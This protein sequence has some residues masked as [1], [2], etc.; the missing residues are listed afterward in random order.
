MIGPRRAGKS[1]FALQLLADY[2]FAYINFDDE[3]LLD[4]DNYDLFI[5]WIREVYGD[6]RYILFDE[7]QN[8]NRWE[9]FVNRLQR[10]GF[11]IIITGS[12]ARLLS[13]ELSTHL[14]GRFIE[15]NIFPFSFRE[16][17]RAK[18]F[19]YD[20]N[21]ISVEMEGN[22]LRALNEYL[23]VGAYPEVI[24]KGLDQKTYLTT[25]FDSVLFKDVVNRYNVRYPSK[26]R[27]LAVNLVAGFAREYSYSRLNE[28]LGFRSVHTVQEYSNYIREVFIYF[29]LKRY[30]FSMRKVIKSP[31]KAY[32]YDTGMATVLKTNIT[33]DYGHL[34]ENAV[35]VEL[36]RRKNEI[37]YWRDKSGW[38]IDFVVKSRTGIES[39]IQV[40]YDFTNKDVKKR[41]I[42]SILKA[43]KELR[44]SRKYI[45]TWDHVEEM[46]ISGEKLYCLPLYRWLL[47]EDH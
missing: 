12:N 19:H 30:A 36:I 27:D 41:E 20:I 11:N 18:K 42:K 46:D 25:L 29:S 38:E 23:Q 44:P 14:T 35:A 47:K 4:I 3:R 22:L 6:T 7:I 2:N 32:A 45:L 26:L 9:L 13:R 33:P 24:T 8:L 39:L 5:K 10:N 28:D 1:V 31:E 40:C 15:L 37:Y 16:Y 21:K 43:T 17:L 34:M